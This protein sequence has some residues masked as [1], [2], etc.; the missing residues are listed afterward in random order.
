MSNSYN[1]TTPPRPLW[2]HIQEATFEEWQGK[3]AKGFLQDW[4]SLTQY[5]ERLSNN[6]SE[7]VSG[8]VVT[9]A[10]GTTYNISAGTYT[11]AG[12]TYTYG[13][14]SIV[15]DAADATNPRYDIIVIDAQGEV[16]VVKGAAQAWPGEPR[17]YDTAVCILVKLFIDPTAA[18]ITEGEIASVAA[19]TITGTISAGQ[20][21]T[22]TAAQ[23]TGT[24]TAGQIDTITAGQITGQLISS[25]I[26]SV[27]ATTITGS[28]V[29]GQIASVAAVTIT[30][31]IL[32]G[33]ID[34]IV[35]GQI[36]G[37][38]ISTQIG[39]INAATI[40]V[41]SIVNSQITSMVAGKL[42]AGTIVGSKLELTA[43]GFETKLNNATYRSITTAFSSL[44][45]STGDD[46]A[47]FPGQ[48]R[49]GVT[50]NSG[51]MVLDVTAG[52]SSIVFKNPS[53]GA[54][55]VTVNG[56]SSPYMNIVSGQY[57]IGGTKVLGSRITGYT[58]FTGTLDRGTAYN[59]ATITLAQ[60]AERVYALQ[61]DLTSHGTIGA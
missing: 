47:I 44:K 29:A 21:D 60:L 42:T 26:A 54:I 58:A 53:T 40:T 50:A 48:I 61:A 14:G 35:A 45:T 32:A 20:I 30:G 36:T 43:G 55:R 5:V 6:E 17:I 39:S 23:I 49:L 38:I 1:I 33:Q 13:G 25:Q 12:N 9:F 18:W 57:R 52:T 46:V 24:I 19:A 22:I 28:I 2:P 51:V 4:D 37:S 34:T 27:A 8:L 15:L 10:S 31:V 3:A 11:V 16:S 59:T 41:G 56:S 7:V